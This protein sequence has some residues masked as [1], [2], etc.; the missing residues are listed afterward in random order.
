AARSPL[1]RLC[2]SASAAPSGRSMRG[3]ARSRGC[4]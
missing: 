3:A 4:G 1:A 2:S